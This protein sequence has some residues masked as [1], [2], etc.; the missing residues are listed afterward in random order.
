MITALSIS[1]EQ[2]EER[3]ALDS[4]NF[5]QGKTRKATWRKDFLNVLTKYRVQDESFK[6][7]L[8]ADS[9]HVCERHFLPE[10]IKICKYK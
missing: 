10:E 7:Q 8:A 3:K 1:V 6:R 9:L 2:V 5:Q 4:S